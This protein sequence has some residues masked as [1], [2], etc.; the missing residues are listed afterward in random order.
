MKLLGTQSNTENG[1]RSIVTPSDS[2]VDTNTVNSVSDRTGSSVGEHSIVMQGFETE[3]IRNVYYQWMSSV[4]LLALEN[5]NLY[6]AIMS[7]SYGILNF[8][9]QDRSLNSSVYTRESS[10]HRFIAVHELQQIVASN[11][12]VDSPEALLATALILSWDIFFQ[13]EDISSYVTLSKG[14]V[15]VLERTLTMS[16]T[17]PNNTVLCM[18]DSLFQG[19]KAVQIPPYSRDVLEE[20]LQKLDSFREY[21]ASTPGLE[22]SNILAQ[23]SSLASFLRDVSCYLLTAKRIDQSNGIKYFPPMYLISLLRRWVRM[24][25]AKA[26]AMGVEQCV[27]QLPEQAVVLYCYYHATTRVLDALFP[28]M[29]Y[30][31]QFGFIGPIELVGIEGILNIMDLGSITPF[32]EF[33]KKIISFFRE[34]LFHYN[35]LIGNRNPLTPDGNPL[36]FTEIQIRSFEKTVIGP[37][38]FPNIAQEAALEND[39]TRYKVATSV[40]AGYSGS[41]NLALLSSVSGADIQEKVNP[42][43]DLPPTP[44]SSR[45]P[46]IFQAYFQ[47]RM[48]ILESLE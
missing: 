39:P 26:L 4:Y 35:R 47:D 21:F 9:S 1:I 30:L 37:E 11:K 22:S 24:F 19:I 14:F 15:A 45:Q 43:V 34:R 29:R 2:S 17:Q 16:M 3:M 40:G 32:L 8:K 38:H 31:F 36:E 6:H 23:Y 13:E 27:R 5:A 28:E 41:S 33:P 46:E 18:S 48:K 7:L 20:I 12:P 44:D 10:K 25:P 42:Q